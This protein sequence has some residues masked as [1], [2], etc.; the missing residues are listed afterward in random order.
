M[1]KVSTDHQQGFERIGFTASKRLRLFLEIARNEKE[2]RTEGT[3]SNSE[4][5]LKETE[6]FKKCEERRRWSDE[7]KHKALGTFKN[8]KNRLEES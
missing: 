7:Y 4:Y 2:K 6:T 3:V 1:R 8:W 5:C